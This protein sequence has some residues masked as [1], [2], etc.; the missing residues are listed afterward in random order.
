MTVSQLVLLYP[1]NSGYVS[2]GCRTWI[3]FYN[4]PF[5]EKVLQKIFI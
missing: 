4:K 2:A 3:M 5:A 1:Q